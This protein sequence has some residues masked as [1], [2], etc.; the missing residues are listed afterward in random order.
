MQ[1]RIGNLEVKRID[2]LNWGVFEVMPQGFDG[3]KKLRMHRVADDG[4]ILKHTG[5]YHG[6]LT[7]ALRRAH[8]MLVADG[9]ECCGFGDLARLV[10]ESE[11]RVAELAE[12]IGAV[13]RDA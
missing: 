2:E 12:R 6:T 10:E 11:R 8:R 9:T 5:T 4:R 3:A 13:A 1:I 7:E